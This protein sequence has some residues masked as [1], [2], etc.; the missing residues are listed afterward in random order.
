MV[1]LYRFPPNSGR[2]AFDFPGLDKTSRDLLIDEIGLIARE[3][4]GPG[5]P[6]PAELYNVMFMERD[7]TQ[8]HRIGGFSVPTEIADD[9][10]DRLISQGHSVE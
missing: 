3:A 9:V 6:N 10:A 2:V 1:T 5:N 8:G 4:G 7:G